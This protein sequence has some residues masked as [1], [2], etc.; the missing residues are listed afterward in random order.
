MYV[1]SAS[2]NITVSAGMPICARS[3]QVYFDSESCKL[4]VIG[5]IDG[6]PS[7]H[8]I[9]MPISNI[10]SSLLD[11]IVND[12]LERKRIEETAN[13]HPLVKE[14]LDQYNIIKALVAK[15]I[16]NNDQ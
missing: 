2:P 5:F 10:T 11:E 3:G 1:T 9:I 7:R 8:E 12:Y 6:H 4:Y 14:A 13:N 16:S 15:E